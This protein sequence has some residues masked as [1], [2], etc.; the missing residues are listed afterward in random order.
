MWEMSMQQ[1]EAMYTE[2][3]AVAEQVRRGV[4]HAP[5]WPVLRGSG[6]FGCCASHA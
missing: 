4:L 2:L 6:V 5:S 1:T 3:E